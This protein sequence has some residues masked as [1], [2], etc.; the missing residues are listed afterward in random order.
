MPQHLPDLRQR[1]AGPQHLGR[2]RVAQP[3]RSPPRQPGPVAGPAHDLA[4][5]LRR[6]LP[7]RPPHGHEHCPRRAAGTAVGQPLGKRLPSR[8]R[9][10][11]PLDAAALARD[12]D[13]ADPPVN[14]A[15]L[16]AGDLGAA[17]PKPR[18]KRQDRVIAAAHERRAVAAGQQPLDLGRR[19]PAGQRGQPP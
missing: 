12:R 10:R 18:Q 1:R 14:I 13:L 11:E 5:R 8:G 3:V 6:Q 17:Q 2:Q 19:H 16:K 4:D 15:Q 7:V 9:Q